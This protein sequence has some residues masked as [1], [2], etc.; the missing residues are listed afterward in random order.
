M[1]A[2]QLQAVQNS[3]Q[4]SHIFAVVVSYLSPSQAASQE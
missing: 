4:N 2:S 3:G 1:P